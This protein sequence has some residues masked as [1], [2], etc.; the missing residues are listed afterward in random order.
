M[1]RKRISAKSQRLRMRALEFLSQASMDYK[2][3]TAD[4]VF[5]EAESVLDELHDVITELQERIVPDVHGL[6]DKIGFALSCI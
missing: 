6:N 4:H 5:E 1:G 2:L 3:E